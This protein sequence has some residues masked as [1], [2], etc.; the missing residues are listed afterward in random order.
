MP[1]VSWSCVDLLRAGTV[2][3][4]DAG[5][6]SDGSSSDGFHSSPVATFSSAGN[7]RITVTVTDTRDPGLTVTSVVD[8]ATC[9][10]R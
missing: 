4:D 7:Y 6:T 8:V 9:S 1:V 3:F 2:T 5:A 10:R